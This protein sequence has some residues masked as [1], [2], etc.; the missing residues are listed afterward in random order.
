MIRGGTFSDRDNEDENG[1]NVNDAMCSGKSCCLQN[2]LRCTLTVLTG[3]FAIL[4]GDVFSQILSIVGALGFSCPA[5]RTK[6][7]WWTATGK[8]QMHDASHRANNRVACAS[9]KQITL[10][11]SRGRGHAKRNT[12]RKCTTSIDTVI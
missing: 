2:V 6:G 12:L 5:M 3:S 11:I 4:F 8:G 10:N 9:R 1:T 7:S